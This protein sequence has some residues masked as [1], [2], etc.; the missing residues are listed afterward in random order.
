MSLAT[1]TGGEQCLRPA[2]GGLDAD[3]MAGLARAYGDMLAPQVRWNTRVPEPHVVRYDPT[4]GAVAGHRP[5]V[6]RLRAADVLPA[7]PVQG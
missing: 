2:L 6:A 7:A 5:V 4:C 3:V 1:E